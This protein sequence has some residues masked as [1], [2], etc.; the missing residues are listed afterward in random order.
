MTRHH[1]PADPVELVVR[2]LGSRR[3]GP[4]PASLRQA[5]LACYDGEFSPQR[6]VGISWAKRLLA[7]AALL[8]A[9]LQAGRMFQ[10]GG[11]PVER[12]EVRNVDII[13][14]EARLAL[15]RAELQVAEAEDRSMDPASATELPSGEEPLSVEARMLALAE[16]EPA[17]LRIAAARALESIDP[18]GAARRYREVLSDYP[19]SPMTAVARARLGVLD[20]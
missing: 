16:T 13:L 6:T 19:S 20:R 15:L 11:E 2:H 12:T 1:E 8:L 10:A 4:E 18:P 14:L 5:I 7:A 3:P 17:V 9:A